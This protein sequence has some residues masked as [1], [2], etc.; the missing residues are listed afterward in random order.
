MMEGDFT[1]DY[2]IHLWGSVVGKGTLTKIKQEGV[3]HGRE[4]ENH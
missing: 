2:C 1:K 3:C 4:T